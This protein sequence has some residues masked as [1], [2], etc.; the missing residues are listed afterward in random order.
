MCDLC[1][2]STRAP[3]DVLDRISADI[4]RRRFGIVSV[5][6]SARAAEFSYTVGLTE[7]GLPELIVTAARPTDA[8]HLLGLWGDYLLD[9]S[10]V[11]PGE[12]LECGPW[13][14]EAVAVEHPEEHLLVAHRFYGGRLR[15]L[16]LAWADERGLWPWQPGHRA[17]RSGQPVLGTPAP[18]YCREHSPDRLDV[19]P[20]L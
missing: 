2:D 15:A 19:P 5:Q 14:L 18:R 7:H 3:D 8:A 4:A 16:Q 9:E 6:R 1:D 20:H 11:L 10:A 17:R 12:T 13:L